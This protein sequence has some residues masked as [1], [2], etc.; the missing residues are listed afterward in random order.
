MW[1]SFVKG[2]IW[3]AIATVAEVPPAVRLPNSHPLRLVYQYVKSL[4]HDYFEL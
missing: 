1:F 3:T 4:G 2:L